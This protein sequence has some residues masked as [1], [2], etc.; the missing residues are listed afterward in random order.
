MHN[1]WKHVDGNASL[2]TRDAIVI[3]MILRQ[4]G[5]TTNLLR[6]AAPSCDSVSITWC[7]YILLSVKPLTS[8]NHVWSVSLQHFWI[9]WPKAAHLRVAPKMTTCSGFLPNS[10]VKPS[11][12]IYR[13]RPGIKT[14][15]LYLP[16]VHVEDNCLLPLRYNIRCHQPKS[17]LKSPTLRTNRIHNPRANFSIPSPEERMNQR[18]DFLA[19]DVV[20]PCYRR[21]TP[22]QKIHWLTTTRLHTSH[23]S[24][25]KISRHSVCL[26]NT[27]YVASNNE[28]P[29][30]KQIWRTNALTATIV[31]TV[32]QLSIAICP[33]MPI[34]TLLW[35]W[36]NPAA[37]G[38]LDQLRLRW[39]QDAGENLRGNYGSYSDLPTRG[40]EKGWA[41]E[42]DYQHDSNLSSPMS[43]RGSGM[44]CKQ[45][46]LHG[47]SWWPYNWLNL[48]S[49]ITTVYSP[50]WN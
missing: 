49:N 35:Q 20:H 46:P 15:Y 7:N 42:R 34:H 40:K 32:S 45:P 8:T 48:V 39:N 38:T 23:K 50:R 17:A 18:L 30:R 37:S 22:L 9:S 10:T 27:H 33:T 11:E 31:Y 29:K 3:T 41:L 43:M 5:A 19:S 12:C 26:Q 4:N 6:I 1:T 13:S 2:S 25:Q 14:L 44:P 16:G 36:E 21:A 24:N 28:S 47:A